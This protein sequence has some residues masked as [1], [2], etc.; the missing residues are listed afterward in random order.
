PTTIT[1]GVPL[2]CVALMALAAATQDA[3][4]LTV[5]ECA[6]AAWFAYVVNVAVHE[7]GHLLA[8]LLLGLAPSRVVVLPFDF[9]RAAD[10]WHVRLSREW[11]VVSGGMVKL[12]AQCQPSPAQ[13]IVFAGAGPAAS[14]LLLLLYLGLNPYRWSDLFAYEPGPVLVL[15][16]TFA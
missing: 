12:H 15:V 14:L 10:G 3:E 4:G 8:A 7:L 2:Y 6:G 1:L 9:S 11:F 16:G 5:G 13:S